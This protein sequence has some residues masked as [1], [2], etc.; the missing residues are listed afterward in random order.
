M[1]LLSEFSNERLLTT[2]PLGPFSV[3][4]N[5]ALFGVRLSK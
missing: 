3:Q 1:P 5:W 2:V 4:S